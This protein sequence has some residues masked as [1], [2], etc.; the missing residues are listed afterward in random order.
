MLMQ[1]STLA[2]DG[3]SSRLT[4]GDGDFDLN[5]VYFG[6]SDLSLCARGEDGQSHGDSEGLHLEKAGGLLICI[7]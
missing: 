1:D 6:D 4:C 5:N 2:N 7:C 3:C